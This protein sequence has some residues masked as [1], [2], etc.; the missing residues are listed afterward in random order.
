MQMIFVSDMIP[1][2]THISYLSYTYHNIMCMNIRMIRGT[3]RT[4]KN[5]KIFYFF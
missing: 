2:Y 3:T 5:K 4:D 1:E